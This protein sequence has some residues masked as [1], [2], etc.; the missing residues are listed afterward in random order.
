MSSGSN[1]D[2]DGDDNADEKEDHVANDITIQ[3]NPALLYLAHYQTWTRWNFQGGS[4]A[5]GTQTEGVK[6]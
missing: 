3:Y 2:E 5:G 6:T 4:Q 1:D